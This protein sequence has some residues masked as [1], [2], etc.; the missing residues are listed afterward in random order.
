M[1]RALGHP[2]TALRRPSD[3][4]ETA[5]GRPAEGP[6]T[7]L[8]WPCRGLTE[9][10]RRGPRDGDIPRMLLERASCARPCL[11]RPLGGILTCLFP[12]IAAG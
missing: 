2:P 1:S 12:L 10:S 6:R 3:R 7:A 4:P 9:G 11:K 5:L 8:R